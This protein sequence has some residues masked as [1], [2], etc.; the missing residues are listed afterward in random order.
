MLSEIRLD[1][2]SAGQSF[3]LTMLPQGVYSRVRFT[4]DQVE[5]EGS[6]RGVPLKVKL[7]Q[8]G[9]G[10]PVDLR[11]NGVEVAPGG[12]A[13]FAISVDVASWFA[14]GLLDSATATQQEILVDAANNPAVAAQLAAR[15]AASFGLHDSPVQ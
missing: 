3:S 2:L 14:G 4:G 10:N 13:T 6:W 5:L 7:E 1:L 8:Q 11:S 9:E 12:V 15:V